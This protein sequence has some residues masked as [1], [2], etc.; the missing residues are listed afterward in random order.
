MSFG[1]NLDN[2]SFCSCCALRCCMH[3]HTLPIRTLA[4]ATVP[5]AM[6]ITSA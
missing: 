5:K 1:A 4:A 2:S 3:K 6:D